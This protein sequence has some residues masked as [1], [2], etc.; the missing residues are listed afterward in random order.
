MTQQ[1][2]GS[3]N[4]T[5]TSHLSCKL[6]QKQSAFFTILI[7]KY[8]ECK[9]YCVAHSD[10][11]MCSLTH[12]QILHYTNMRLQRVASEIEFSLDVLPT[13]TWTVFILHSSI[14]FAAKLLLRADKSLIMC[15]AV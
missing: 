9:D 8:F 6:F 11:K 3:C 15:R 12:L 13:S 7:E 1:S 14:G 2:D 5:S 10:G 4:V